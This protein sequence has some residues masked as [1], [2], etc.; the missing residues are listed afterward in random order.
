[1]WG[2]VKGWPHCTLTEYDDER[3]MKPRY[4]TFLLK[5]DIRSKDKNAND[6]LFHF[7]VHH[8]QRGSQHLYVKTEREM[9]AWEKVL[10]EV[11]RGWGGGKRSEALL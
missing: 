11:R 8:A 6:Q 1:M 7:N 3:E 9:G 10:T 4:V 2:V 5:C